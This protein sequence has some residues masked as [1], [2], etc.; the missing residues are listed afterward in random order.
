MMKNPVHCL[1]SSVLVAALVLIS[2]TPLAAQS[3]TEREWSLAATGDSIIT[4]RIAIYDDPAFMS[5]VKVIRDADVAFTNLEISLFR[6]WEFEGYP[7][8]ESGGNWE[9]GPPEAAEE[10][11]L[12]QL[13]GL[14]L[15]ARDHRTDA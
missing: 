5:L 15:P 1:S 6:L 11:H 2:A 9:I 14:R 12:L 3:T 7:Q 4:R 13:G 8:A 10:A